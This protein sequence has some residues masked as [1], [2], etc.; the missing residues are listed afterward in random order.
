[1]FVRKSLENR[2]F[3]ILI[4]III[5]LLV[6]AAII[7]ISPIFGA[8]TEAGSSV[9]IGDGAVPLASSPITQEEQNAAYKVD[10]SIRYGEPVSFVPVN[11]ADPPWEAVFPALDE[12]YEAAL[13]LGYEEFSREKCE[14]IYNGINERRIQEGLGPLWYITSGNLYKLTYIRAIEIMDLYSHDRPDGT[15]S[16]TVMTDKYIG[17]EILNGQQTVQETL[18][19][20]FESPTHLETILCPL[21][22]EIAVVG[23]EPIDGEDFGREAALF[24]I[25]PCE[26]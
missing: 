11:Y 10:K 7:G 25:R 14:Y 17:G 24:G 26:Y 9:I 4:F 23:I 19:T 20:W 2:I 15:N 16:L 21:F 18:K 8:H 1:V 13:A 22:T 6:A 12:Q 5:G 3:S